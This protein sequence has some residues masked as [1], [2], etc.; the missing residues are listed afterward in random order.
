M[1]YLLSSELDYRGLICDDAGP[2]YAA[3]LGWTPVFLREWQ[4]QD[5]IVVV[6][7]RI[8]KNECE[9][10]ERLISDRVGFRFVFKIV[11]PCYESSRWTS[12]YYDFL[13][14]VSGNARVA[15]LS[16]YEPAEWVMDLS[17][18]VGRR[19]LCVLPYPY[20]DARELPD[21]GKPRIPKALI[22]GA[23][24]AS[25]YPFR[26]RMYRAYANSSTFREATELLEHPGYPDI[27]RPLTHRRIGNDYI[28]HLSTYEWM[29][30]CPSRAKL[31]FMKYLECAYAGCAPTGESPNGLPD[32]AKSCFLKVPTG[33]GWKFR[34]RAAVQDEESRERAA[35]YRKTMRE[36]RSPMLLNEQF[37]CWLGSAFK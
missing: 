10:L 16:V 28:R 18:Q 19:R 25:I 34:F 5:E 29:L 2:G 3:N 1:I 4:R 23:R 8:T 26:E 15:F 7:N 31:E 24:L 20:S 13:K 6:D 36:A 9:L 32:V 14:R 33:L 37:R 17:R 11:D 30:L 22:S 35:L 12:W 21:S 27:G